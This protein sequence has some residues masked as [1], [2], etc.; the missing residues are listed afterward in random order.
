MFLAVVLVVTAVLLLLY[1]KH[2]NNDFWKKVSA[3]P[4][5]KPYPL[6]GS[7]EWFGKSP[8]KKKLLL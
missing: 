4:G 3:I 7:I 8:G 1:R 5:N 2:Q 6:L